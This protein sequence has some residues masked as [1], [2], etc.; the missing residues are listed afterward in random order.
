MHSEPVNAYRID[1]RNKLCRMSVP[2]VRLSQARESAGYAS[3]ADA[4]NALGLAYATYAAHENGSRGFTAQ[5]AEKYARKFRVSLEWLLTGRGE[6]RSSGVKYAQPIVEGLPV[7][8]QVKAGH[9]LDVSLTEQANEPEM[10]GVARDSRFPKA[11]QY[12]LHVVGDSMDRDYPD[13]CYVI[14]VDFAESGLELRDGLV[15]HVERTRSAGQLVENTLKIARRKARG[16]ELAPNSTNPTYKPLL[17][18]GADGDEI[19]VR[20]VVVGEFR[21]RKL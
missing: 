1:G 7:L 16:W 3:A 4:A 17:L 20:G 8:G 18:D 13:G 2:S 12:L 10:M 9:W 11:K 5:S 19:A 21:W 15:V 14:C 6:M